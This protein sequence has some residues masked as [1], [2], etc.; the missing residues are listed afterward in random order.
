[1]FLALSILYSLAR[2]DNIRTYFTRWYLFFL[3]VHFHPFNSIQFFSF[4]LCAI[5]CFFPV[6]RLSNGIDIFPWHFCL[7]N[8]RDILK[9]IEV[10]NFTWGAHVYNFVWTANIVYRTYLLNFSFSLK[11]FM[12]VTRLRWHSSDIVFILFAI[13]SFLIQMRWKW[14]SSFSFSFHSAARLCF[15]TDDGE[16]KRK[17]VVK[18]NTINSAHFESDFRRSCKVC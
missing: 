7:D 1:M 12:V 6:E 15:V 5:F 2:H 10:V 16:K 14:L 3:S 4:S 18:I 13:D 11:Y 8:V 9:H 17:R